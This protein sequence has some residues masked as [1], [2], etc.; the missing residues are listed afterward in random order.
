MICTRDSLRGDTSRS[1]TPVPP[2]LIGGASSR[3]T[4]WISGSAN[5]APTGMDKTWQSCTSVA[6]LG[7][8]SSRSR[9][10]M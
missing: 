10:L 2:R 7:E 4:F 1:C 3:V 8:V 6:T 5:R 9:R